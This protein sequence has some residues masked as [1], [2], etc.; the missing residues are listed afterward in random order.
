MRCSNSS[1][2]ARIA[3]SRS[4][5]RERIWVL[6]EAVGLDGPGLGIITDDV[7]SGASKIVFLY[8]VMYESAGI[9]HHTAFGYFFQGQYV[10]PNH[11]AIVDI[12]NDA[13]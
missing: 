2:T 1:S 10:R 4:E 7:M 9:P 12:G 5:C 13:D 11:L 3:I 8:C 6:I